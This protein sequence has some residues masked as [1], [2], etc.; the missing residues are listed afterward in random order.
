MSISPLIKAKAELTHGSR[1]NCPVVLSTRV[2]LARN[3][4]DIPFPGWAKESH[5]REVFVRLFRGGEQAPAN[6]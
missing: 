2:R 6:G 1:V 5:R 3:L 4:N